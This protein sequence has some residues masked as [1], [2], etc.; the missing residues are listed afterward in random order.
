MTTNIFFSWQADTPNKVGRTF[1]KEVLDEVCKSFTTDTSLNEAF[2]DIII[3]S[4]TQ[5]V[6]GQPPI[7]ETIFKKIDSSAV[8]IA[9]M[10]LTGIRMDKRPTP[11]PNVL[12]EYGWALKSLTNERVIC[13]MNTVYGEPSNEN[14]PFDLAH[15]RWPIR[16]YLPENATSKT[17]IAEKEKLSKILKKAIQMSLAI[18]PATISIPESVFPS[19]IANDGPARFRSKNEPIGFEDGIFDENGKEVFLSSGPTIW[20]RIMPSV[21]L[22]KEWPTWE[23]KKIAMG[24]SSLMPL[25]HPS[26]GYS[27]VRA[28]DGEGMYRSNG[29]DTPGSN[30]IKTDSV[31]F[32]FKTGEVWS[33][34]TALLGYKNEWLPMTD[35]ENVFVK[36]IQA[37][38]SFLKELDID[39]PYHWKAGLIGVKGRRLGYAPPPG[40]MWIRDGGPLCASDIIEAEG[41]VELGQPATTA[42]LPLFKKVF[43]EC[44]LERPDY[45]PQ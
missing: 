1:L 28:S 4:D 18:I 6:A 21:K 16:Y 31:A 20:L 9:D 34:E 32:V 25:I 43:E 24:K 39:L 23:L 30:T 13:V 12:I 27:Y 22:P 26:G 29:K 14:L 15:L 37:Y 8:F 38:S 10:T 44:G 40:K 36:G 45:L 41:Q 11:N 33:I 19:A 7:A 2:R 17:K 42:L 5:G 35:I 3:D